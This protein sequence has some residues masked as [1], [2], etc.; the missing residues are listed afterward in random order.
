[1][2]SRVKTGLIFARPCEKTLSPELC[3][4]RMGNY[5]F[6]RNF[7]IFDPVLEKAS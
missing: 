4:L 6:P 3:S 2:L 5:R 1:M 7:L